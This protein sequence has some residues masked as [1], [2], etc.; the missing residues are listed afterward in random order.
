MPVA[1]VPTPGFRA[2]S[3]GWS[4]VALV[5]SVL[6]AAGVFLPLM[7]LRGRTVDRDVLGVGIAL[8]WR[9]FDDLFVLSLFERWDLAFV[10][11]LLCAGAGVVALTVPSRAW[12][13]AVGAVLAAVA[14]HLQLALVERAEYLA[15]RYFESPS[16]SIGSV[17]TVGGAFV[18]LVGFVVV[19][20]RRH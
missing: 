19:L 14:F 15:I 8:P 5:G 9:A 6:S 7:T 2:G 13:A 16:Y 11:L 17:M 4:I 10:V 20:A 12:P 1:G 18:A 3:F